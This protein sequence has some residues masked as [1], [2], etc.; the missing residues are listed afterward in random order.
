MIPLSRLCNGWWWRYFGKDATS[1]RWLDRGIFDH[2]G[3]STACFQCILSF[4]EMNTWFLT[5]HVKSSWRSQK[6]YKF[7]LIIPTCCMLDFLKNLWKKAFSIKIFL[8]HPKKYSCALCF[9]RLSNNSVFKMR[10][11]SDITWWYGNFQK[12]HFLYSFH[13]S[14]HI[15][16]FF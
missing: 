7:P 6:N 10:G 16:R 4:F 9:F 11:M 15:Q 13:L 14:D 1:C 2:F 8:Q 12:L 3:S 5:D